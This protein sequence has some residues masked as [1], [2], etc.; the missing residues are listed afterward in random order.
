MSITRRGAAALAGSLL[1]AAAGVFSNPTGAQGGTL[2]GV[3]QVGK[4]HGLWNLPSAAQAGFASGLLVASTGAP[5][6][7]MKAT[8]KQGPAAVAGMQ[9]TIDGTLT[10]ISPAAV[11]PVPFA[12]IHGKW[13][14]DAGGF[15]KF[16]AY[17]VKLGPTAPAT[18]AVIG[19][20]SGTFLDSPLSLSPTGW[21]T[22][23]GT[24]KICP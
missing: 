4:V 18:T 23:Q 11:V 8:V 16:Q 1:M 7:E 14:A 24:W 9:G 3:C 6:Y 12:E 17:V 15:G 10:K 13:V 5:L 20:I 21:G 22:F 2:A 19:Q